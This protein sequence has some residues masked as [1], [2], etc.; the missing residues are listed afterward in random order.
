M[1]KLAVNAPSKRYVVHIGKNMLDDADGV[2]ACIHS[3][4]VLVVTNETVAPL[5]LNTLVNA[6]SSHCVCDTLVLPD[7]EQYKNREQLERIYEALLT[8]QHHRDTTLIA[9]GGGVI[10]DMVGFAAST[11]LRGVSFINMPTTLLAQVDAAI[12]GKT[13]INHALGK[14]MIGSFYQ[15]DAVFMDLNTLNTLPLRAFRAGIA[16]MIKCALI[17]GGVLLEHMQEALAQGLALHRYSKLD[18]LLLECC[19]VKAFIVAQDEKEQGMR[20]LLNLG[21]TLAHALETATDYQRFLHGE[22]VAIGLNAAMHLSKDVS[23]LPPQSVTKVKE[24]LHAA[25]LPLVIPEDLDVHVLWD[26]MTRDK[27]A[28]GDHLRWILMREF[29]DCI[30]EENVSQSLVMNTLHRLAKG[31]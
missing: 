26:I 12:G 18:E 31:D 15:P 10:G 24:M 21:H 16:E 23:G 30:I 9:L 7:G 13:A 1:L 14:N 28:K 5:Y 27:K 29:G 6:L 17:R 11:Y 3:P 25:H 20:A 4:R 8:H 19:T 2:R 22:A